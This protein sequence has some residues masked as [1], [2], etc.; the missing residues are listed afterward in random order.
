[1]P[2]QEQDVAQI[3]AEV[4]GIGIDEVDVET[5]FFDL[6][7]GS[8]LLIKLVD[9]LHADLGIETNIV[10]LLEYSTIAEFVSYRN[11]LPDE[12]ESGRR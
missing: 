9:R 8:L 4:I 11:A 7:G 5:N 3:W 12:A 2:V 10:E 1:M 6:G